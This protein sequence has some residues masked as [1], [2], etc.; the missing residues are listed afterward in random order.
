MA[1]LRTLRVARTTATYG[2]QCHLDRGG[3]SS[4]WTQG[5]QNQ[6]TAE[7]T[8]ATYVAL[9]G[10]EL[11]PRVD[12]VA[13][14]DGDPHKEELEQSCDR[15]GVLQ[16]VDDHP[17]AWQTPLTLVGPLFMLPCFLPGI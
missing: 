2:K 11:G 16:R 17:N 1:G 3:D 4:K 7:I 12:C 9:A 14:E 5:K 13:L 15:L 6:D 10:Q 8:V